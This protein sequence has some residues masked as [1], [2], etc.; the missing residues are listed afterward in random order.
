MVTDDSRTCVYYPICVATSSNP[1]FTAK[2][3]YAFLICFLYVIN[4]WSTYIIP[5][6]MILMI[7]AKLMKFS[8][9]YVKYQA[10]R[11]T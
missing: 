6:V 7:K 3:L 9:A 5:E 8:C 2:M 10:I 1:E 4:T 11:F